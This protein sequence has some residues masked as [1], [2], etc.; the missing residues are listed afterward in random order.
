MLN[1]GLLALFKTLQG[2]ERSKKKKKDRLA[3]MFKE[4]FRPKAGMTGRAPKR[5]GLMGGIEDFLQGGP[6]IDWSQFEGPPVITKGPDGGV[7]RVPD[8][9]RG[10]PEIHAG[11]PPDQWSDPEV[12]Q[13]FDKDRNFLGWNRSQTN[14]TT[15]KRTNQFIP[16][17]DDDDAAPKPHTLPDGREALFM[18]GD[19]GWGYY[20]PLT[21][22]RIEDGGAYLKPRATT[23]AD[24]MHKAYVNVQARLDNAEETGLDDGTIAKLK[25]L[26]KLLA[27]RMDDVTREALGIAKMTP[28]EEEE[29]ILA[30]KKDEE[31]GGVWAFMKDLW[32]SMGWKLPAGVDIA[33]KQ[34]SEIYMT[35]GLASDESKSVLESK[36]IE[37]AK[38]DG[39]AAPDEEAQHLVPAYIF[40][41][42]EPA[43]TIYKEH[44]MRAQKAA[45]K[46]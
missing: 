24:A 3:E 7:V 16:A 14:T 12:E 6:N 13:V 11:T 26:Q 23:D 43:I 9:G 41:R 4:G 22:Q 10:I 29:F 36:D 20:D 46:V 30:G 45:K 19:K 25:E 21:R 18:K 34:M 42:G 32:D 39:S 5:S 38:K 1:T 27:W 37:R 35:G 8:S 33:G 2:A 44:L 40:E 28:E 31:E 17:P 15:N